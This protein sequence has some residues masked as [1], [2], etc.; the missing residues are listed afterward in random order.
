MFETELQIQFLS[1]WH[2]GSGLG[3]ERLQ[4]LFSSGM[5]MAFPIFLVLQ[6]REP[7]AREH[8]GL[9]VVLQSLYR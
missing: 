2:V 7:C 3:D 5:F 1:D 9:P 8:G 4:T 6:S